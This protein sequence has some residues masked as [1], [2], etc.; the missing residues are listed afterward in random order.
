MERIA[1]AD[2][3]SCQPARGPRQPQATERASMKVAGPPGGQRIRRAA[4]WGKTTYAGSMAEDLRRRLDAMDFINQ[5]MLFAATLLLCFFPSLIV[6]SALAAGQ[7]GM[8]L[9][10][11]RRSA[12]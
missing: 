3:S 8:A 5:G 4:E 1:R 11:T 10:P 12:P 6:A 9:W 2:G 7:D